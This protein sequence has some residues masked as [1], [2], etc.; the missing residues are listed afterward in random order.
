MF[1]FLKVIGMLDVWA[2][3][4]LVVLHF[5]IATF[6]VWTKCQVSKLKLNFLVIYKVYWISKFNALNKCYV[7]LMYEINNSRD[8]C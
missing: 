7:I 8:L 6:N 2:L 4:S 1:N 3:D 5:Q